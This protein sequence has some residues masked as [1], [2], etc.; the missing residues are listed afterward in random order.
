MRLY[1]AGIESHMNIVFEEKPKYVLYSY[2]YR[3][4]D[5]LRYVKSEHCKSFILDSGAFTFMD[6]GKK[7]DFKEYAK[8]YAK[9][10]KENNIT[11]YIELD[12]YD[13]IGIKETEELRKILISITGRKPIPVF[14]RSCGKEYFHKLI[15]EFEYIAIGG[16]AKKDIKRNEYKYFDYFIN[17][18]HKKNVKIHGLGLT[19]QKA[20]KRYKFDSIDS[21]TWIRGRFGDVYSYENG[22]M[23]VYKKKNSRLKSTAEA[24]KF[25]LNQWIK[26]QKYADRYL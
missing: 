5:C 8:Q 4:D 11:N 7:I 18:T 14:H 9:Y 1:L 21:T 6:T 10:V 25:C 22:N 15:N 2:I 26:F 24:N 20:M 23:K 16:I 3:N 12:L 13:I 17:E 19:S